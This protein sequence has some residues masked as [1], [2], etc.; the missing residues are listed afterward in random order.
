MS[1]AFVVS[2]FPV[3]HLCGTLEKKLFC[4]SCWNLLKQNP[5]NFGIYIMYFSK[6]VTAV[7][8]FHCHCLNFLLKEEPANSFRISLLLKD[9][10]SPQFWHCLWKG[11]KNSPFIA[12]VHCLRLVLYLPPIFCF[13]VFFSV[14]LSPHICCRDPQISSPEGCAHKASYLWLFSWSSSPLVAFKIP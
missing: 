4:L 3:P 14:I 1:V 5:R 2:Q 8:K 13:F 12:H 11:F 10:G 7:I 6:C 9:V